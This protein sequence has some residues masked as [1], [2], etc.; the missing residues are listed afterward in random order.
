MDVF[1]YFV[2]GIVGIFLLLVIGF[3]ELLVP[4]NTARKEK[5]NASHWGLYEGLDP[6]DP[7][8]TPTIEVQANRR[9]HKITAG[10]QMYAAGRG[11]KMS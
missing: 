11:V 5:M 1:F 8:Q 6:I 10:S 2:C 4:P 7:E 9:R 3:P